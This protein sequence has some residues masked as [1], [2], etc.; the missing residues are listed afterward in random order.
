MCLGIPMKLIARLDGDRGEVDLDGARQTVDVSLVADP[1][2]G[3][4]VIVHA[5]YAI[6]KLD[7]READERIA[8]FRDLAAQWDAERAER[9]APRSGRGREESAPPSFAPV[10]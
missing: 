8:L 2:P 1:L 4:Y 3:D 9:E 7:C 6:E 5:G 10:P